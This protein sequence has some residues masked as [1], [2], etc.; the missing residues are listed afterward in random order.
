MFPGTK[1][2]NWTRELHD[3]KTTYP[4]GETREDKSDLERLLDLEL[5]LKNACAGLGRAF[6]RRPEIRTAAYIGER[7]VAAPA[8]DV[9][10]G[11]VRA[12]EAEAGEDDADG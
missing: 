9:V 1:T 2:G 10:G 6:R 8:V 12:D 3:W 11:R 7:V 4:N 5:A